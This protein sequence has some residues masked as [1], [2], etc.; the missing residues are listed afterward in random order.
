MYVVSAN[1]NGDNAA[2]TTCDG[3]TG[4]PSLWQPKYAADGN[5]ATRWSTCVDQAATQY[6]EVDLGKVLAVD[7]LELNDS[8][9]TAD[10]ATSYNV[11]VSTDNVTFTTVATS[12][13]AAAADL[14]VAFTPVSARYVR[15]NQT[16]V[17]A[18]RWWSVDEI[19]I[20]CTPDGGL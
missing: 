13:A 4:N 18:T 7:G 9:D 6:I 1:P 20:R 3:I 16:G 5:L 2:H 14:V 8:T 11:Q 15:F 19:V 10:V 12:A 17:S